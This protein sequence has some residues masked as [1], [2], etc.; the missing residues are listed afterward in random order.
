MLEPVE[1]VTAP[2]TDGEDH[3]LHGLSHV[4]QIAT[5]VLFEK[6]IVSILF[7]LDRVA[8]ESASRISIELC[9]DIEGSVGVDLVAGAGAEIVID[10]VRENVDVALTIAIAVRENTVR[11]RCVAF[12]T[13]SSVSKLVGLHNVKF[14]APVATNL[15]GIAVLER[16]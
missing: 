1:T 4:A 5:V 2:V 7:K 12:V 14:W 6:H 3:A 11:V 9:F 10:A 16:I 8:S 15:V 13:S